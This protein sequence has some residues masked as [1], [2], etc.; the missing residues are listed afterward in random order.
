MSELYHYGVPGMRRGVR[1]TVDRVRRSV[2]WRDLTI[3]RRH[4]SE[5]FVGLSSLTTSVLLLFPLYYTALLRYAHLQR[6]ET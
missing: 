2:K 4:Y 1:K 6:V 5:I 3:Q